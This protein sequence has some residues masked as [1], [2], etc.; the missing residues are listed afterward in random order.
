M[1]FD[2]YIGQVLDNRY[3]IVR[4]IGKGGMAIVFEAM[5][6]AMKRIVAL[7][8]LKDDISRDPQSVKRFINESKAISMLSHPNI[9]SIYDI[10]IRGDLKYIVME[11]VEGITLKNYIARKGALSPREALVYTQQILKALEHAHSK[12]IIHRDIKPQNIMLLKSGVIKVTDFGIAKLPNAETVTV[13]DKAI[14]TVYY[15][16]PE[17]AS[18][19]PI[20]PRSDIYSLGIVMYEMLTGKL[21]FM[22]D[23][24]VSVALKQINEQPKSPK[25][26]VP[27]L[28]VGVEQIILT[29]M[30]KKSDKRFQSATA[31]RKHVEQ[32]LSNPNFVFSDKRMAAVA[33]PKGVKG[34]FSKLKK[35][36]SNA[37]RHK[38]SMLPIIAGISLSFILIL[39]I[40][41]F[42]VI[43]SMFKDTTVRKEVIVPDL[44]NQT[45]SDELRAELENMGFNVIIKTKSDNK[46]NPYVILKQDPVKGSKK[47]IIEGQ[48]RCDITLTVNIGKQTLMLPDYAL[49]EYRAT[50][51]KLE[52]MGLRSTI[53]FEKHDLIEEG[54]ILRT[55]PAPNTMVSEGDIIKIIVSEG[56]D[57]KY[58][59][60]PDLKGKTVEKALELL[61]ENKL[62][63]G[64]IVYEGSDKPKGEVLRQSLAAGASVAS[65]TEIDLVLSKGVEDTT[66]PVRPDDIP[67]P[68]ITNKYI[69]DALKMLNE[70]NLRYEV[71]PEYSKTVKVGHVIRTLPKE[72][73]K[74]TPSSNDYNGTV[75]TLYVSNGEKPPETTVDT[76]TPAITTGKTESTTKTP[77]T[78]GK[79]PETTN[80]PQATTSP[81]TT[82]KKPESTGNP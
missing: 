33:A 56:P 67:M 49:S 74:V 29:A 57:V 54:L 3:K 22:A 63:I 52:Q 9:V 2:K 11:R 30:E 45:Y 76:T 40:T 25:E 44:I 17:Q 48:Q 13:A 75:V 26:L 34:F 71:L 64:N 47:V 80:K 16:S 65:G 59:L 20:D 55:E 24:P 58:S 68:D 6:I 28:P 32:I 39:G 27:S 69:D 8:V 35:K 62:N 43:S 70:L 53:V 81:E 14:G 72:G 50:R 38:D 12:G 60:M 21:P 18:G 4:V 79:T 10:S 61:E 15:I 77:E 1:E 46:N 37:K 78:T 73:D 31:M 42:F 23:T 51:I 36:K 66:A 41:L 5:D 7:K 82:G 19:K